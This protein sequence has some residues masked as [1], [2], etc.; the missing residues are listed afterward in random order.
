VDVGYFFKKE[1]EEGYVIR[2][3]GERKVSYAKKG[4]KRGKAVYIT[5]LLAKAWTIHS[6]SLLL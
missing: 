2:R 1:D 4:A 5:E 6:W 3:Q